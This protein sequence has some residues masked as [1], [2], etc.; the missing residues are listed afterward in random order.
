[1]HFRHFERAERGTLRH[2]RQATR[3]EA[4]EIASEQLDAER[5]REAS[6]TQN[7]ADSSVERQC[8]IKPDVTLFPLFTVRWVVHMQSETFRPLRTRRFKSVYN[9]V[10]VIF[11]QEFEET[12][13][14]YRSTRV[15]RR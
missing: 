1:M 2:A 13:E 15:D 9:M 6:R 11:R 14:M 3:R 10:H 5:T 8:G 12:N 4:A 7:A